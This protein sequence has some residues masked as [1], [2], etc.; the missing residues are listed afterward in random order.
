[1]AAWASG[2]SGP[3]IVSPALGSVAR[4][5]RPRGVRAMPSG[6]PVGECHE[7]ATTG[8]LWAMRRLLP[9]RVAA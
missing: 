5:M 8:R 9:H 6:W 7:T 4:S 3:A 1:M 2:V